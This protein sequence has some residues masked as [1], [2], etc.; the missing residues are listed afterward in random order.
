MSQATE[1]RTYGN[2]I[3]ILDIPNLVE[4]Q[5]ESYRD[6]LQLGVPSD[7]RQNQGLEEIIREIFPV[8]SYDESMKL[9]YLSY[10]LGRPRYS[11]D[12]CRKLRLT[13]GYPFKIRVRL[14]KG[15][16]IEEDVYLG[17]VPIMIGGGE[18]L[19]NGAERVIVSQLHRSPGVDFEEEQILG[20]R[21]QHSCWIIPERGSWI[22]INVTKKDTLAVRI[23]QS[24]KFPA[25]TLLRAMDPT[26]S[27][28]CDIIRL[29][30]KVKT[31]KLRT[32][33]DPEKLIGFYAADDLPEGRVE[34]GSRGL[35]RH[36]PDPRR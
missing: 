16:I 11:Q 27:R 22:E 18:F 28:D 2:F 10:E 25:M 23:D 5:T 3:E 31:V 1:V 14:D 32:K 21:R 8:T 35:G 6:F 34:W 12:E 20:D 7:R 9:E 36:V 13:Y 15:D 26:Y 30:H 33:K 29:F 17:E 4:L 24:G 19:I